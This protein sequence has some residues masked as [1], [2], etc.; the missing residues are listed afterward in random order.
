MKKN[1]KF[2][3]GAVLGMAILGTASVASAQTPPYMQSNV[4]SM[5]YNQADVR[6]ALH[7]LFK[8]VPGGAS[9]TIASDVQ[10]TITL[11]LKNVS[12]ETALQNITRQVDATYHIEGGVVN[13]IHRIETVASNPQPVSDIFVD[14]NQKVIRRLKIRSADPMLIA[15]LLSAKTGSTNMSLIPERT[16]IT[17]ARL[18]GGGGG[19]QSGGFGGGGTGG[20]GGGG[21]GGG[22]NSG[23]FGNGGGTSPGG[24]GSFGGGSGTRG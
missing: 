18:L 22:G 7:A 19:G 2:A 8:T 13:I 5:E 24:G 3:L 6:E 12:F 23:G 10:G 15:I 20:N 14:S 16:T 4:S 17:N 11:S 21:F 1:V 9:F